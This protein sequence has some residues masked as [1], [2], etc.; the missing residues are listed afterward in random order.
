MEFSDKKSKKNMY[1]WLTR[2]S[3]D[4]EDLQNWS[5]DHLRPVMA[6]AWHLAGV[7][8]LESDSPNMLFGTCWATIGF[9]APRRRHLRRRSQRRWGLSHASGHERGTVGF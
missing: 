2:L 5:G 1:S 8:P 6:K 3:H 9:I 4:E 7:R